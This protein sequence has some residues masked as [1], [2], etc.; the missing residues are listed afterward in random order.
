MG[1]EILDAVRRVEEG[2]GQLE[3]RMEEVEMENEERRRLETERQ[4]QR[5]GYLVRDKEQTVLRTEYM[6]HPVRKS[7]QKVRFSQHGNQISNINAVWNPTEVEVFRRLLAIGINCGLC[8]TLIK[9]VN[10]RTSHM[11][12]VHKKLP[13]AMYHDQVFTHYKAIHC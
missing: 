9:T 3:G 6:F 5:R 2:L 10:G 11:T 12:K 8:G 13:M 1:E 4:Q 7:A